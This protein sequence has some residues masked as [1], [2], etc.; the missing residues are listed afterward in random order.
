MRCYHLKLI[1]ASY[2]SIY[3][4]LAIQVALYPLTV[5]LR[6]LLARLNTI[7]RVEIIPYLKSNLIWLTSLTKKSCLILKER[8]ISLYYTRI[9]STC[10]YVDT[11]IPYKPSIVVTPSIIIP[12][13]PPIVPLSSFLLPSPFS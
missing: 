13:Y 6:Y 7:P 9:Y 1:R 2:R 8:F 11:T 5:S 3:H 12:S 4:L 10:G